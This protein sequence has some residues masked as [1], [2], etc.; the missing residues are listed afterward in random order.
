MKTNQIYKKR[1]NCRL[2]LSKD[3]KK[4]FEIGKT[5]IS[6]KYVKSKQN[7]IPK[8]KLDL[9]MCKTCHHVQVVHVINPKYL[10]SEY[11]FETGRDKNLIKH[12]QQYANKVCK[13]KFLEKKDL[14][15]DIGSN[16]GTLLKSFDKN[17]YKN[18]LGIDPA[19]D[20]AKKANNLGIRTLNSFFDEK[21]SSL[22]KKKYG[23]AKIV[24]ANNVFAH[25]DDLLSFLKS[26]K[27]ILSEDGIFIFEASYLLDIIKKQLIGTIFHEHLSYHS[28]ISL[29]KFFE[30][31]G[32]NFFDV[33][34]NKQQGGSIIGYVTKNK[35]I[36]VSKK[37]F[38]L[39]KLEK[40]NYL[41]SNKCFLSF[42]K[43]LKQTKKNI[44]NLFK[45]EKS[46]SCF[47]SSRSGTTIMTYFGMG[48][49]IQYI[50]DDNKSKHYKFSPVNQI[51]VYPSEEIYKKKVNF[52][53]IMAWIHEKKIILNHK[54]FLNN[55]GKFV[56]LYPKFKII[57]K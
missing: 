53:F 21:V 18:V 54:D 38:K 30:N 1:N 33:E 52:L 4:V 36:K 2:C 14:I 31:N 8:I 20:I 45:K 9:Y 49:K 32:L 7:K 16:D 6:E 34:R 17:G 42:E 46:L 40:K 13:F 26:I 47:G 12:F 27:N 11:T 5:P 48:E 55:S 50:F 23:K 37:I 24:T 15:V 39:I 29:K 10:W 57:K 43:K 41:D 51:K 35:K 19:K 25:N 3:I 28:I 22:I 44:N 56:S